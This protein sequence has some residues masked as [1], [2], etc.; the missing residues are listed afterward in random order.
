MIDYADPY[1]DHD[2]HD[3]ERRDEEA[4]WSAYWD[5]LIDFA[6]EFE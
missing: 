5:A 6:M 1:T 2:P 4:Y 3:A